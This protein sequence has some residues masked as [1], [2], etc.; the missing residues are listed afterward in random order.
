MVQILFL[1]IHT[2]YIYLLY[3]YFFI[4]LIINKDWNIS[5]YIK[6]IYF[7][8]IY[9]HAKYQNILFLKIY[10]RDKKW[11]ISGD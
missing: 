4:Y 7:F 11:P 2:F 10:D 9:P 6:V 1:L 3:F 8:I 5:Y